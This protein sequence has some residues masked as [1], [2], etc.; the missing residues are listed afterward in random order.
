MNTIG[1]VKKVSPT[2]VVEVWESLARVHNATSAAIEKDMLPSA[3]IP[4]GWYEVLAHLNRAPDA[5]LRFQDLARLAGITDSGASRRIE[6]MIKAGLIDR[7]SCPV[8]RR[9][10][11]AHLTVQGKAAYEKAHTVFVRSLE[12]NLGSRL[13]AEEADAVHA[14]LSRL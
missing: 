7:R 6:Q 5:M 13:A 2:K 12:Q 8:D 14:A 1:D 4:L 3:G 9:G 10:V 11:Y